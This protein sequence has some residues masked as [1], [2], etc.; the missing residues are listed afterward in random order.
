M[1]VPVVKPIPLCDDIIFKKP[2][3]PAPRVNRKSN[4]SAKTSDS[5]TTH[6]RDLNENATSLSE[7]SEK[8]DICLNR[9]GEGN[10]KNCSKESKRE[11][12]KCD[13]P[14]SCEET[15][16]TD[17]REVNCK[18]DCGNGKSN[19]DSE[20]ERKRFNLREKHTESPGTLTESFNCED[21]KNIE[22]QETCCNSGE[23]ISTAEN[24]DSPATLHTSNSEAHPGN[25]SESDSDLSVKSSTRE[26]EN[27]AM[28]RQVTPNQPMEEE[29]LEPGEIM[30]HPQIVAKSKLQLLNSLARL[31]VTR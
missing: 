22:S 26:E 12:I 19:F 25:T 24:T 28:S 23:I 18:L 21:W 4:S 16:G 6:T 13:F 17:L 30:P 8:Q 29:E 5:S 27:L 7:T 2:N 20:P 31:D 1:A 11:Q 3:L 14:C 15:R 9:E 10:T